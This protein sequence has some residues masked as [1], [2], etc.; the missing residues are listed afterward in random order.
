M[1]SK[2]IFLRRILT[3][4]IELIKIQQ[5]KQQQLLS[6]HQVALIPPAR[7]VGLQIFRA[8]GVNLL[9]RGLTPTILRDVVG[10]GLYFLGVRSLS[11]SL[12]SAHCAHILNAK[13]ST[14]ARYAS[15]RRPRGQTRRRPRHP[16]APGHRFSSRVV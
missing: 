16:R 11:P 10:Y 8:G 5:Q 13:R 3:T 1:G 6:A 14:K 15:S 4:P 12:H 7:T 9:Y 2:P